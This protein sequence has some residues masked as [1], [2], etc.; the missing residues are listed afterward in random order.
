VKRFAPFG[1]ITSAIAILG[2]ALLARIFREPG[3]SKAVWT[4]AAAAIAVQLATFAVARRYANSGK[5]MI[6]WGIGAI[7]RVAALAAYGFAATG[8]LGLPLAPA[9]LSFALFVFVSTVIEPL[10]LSA[11]A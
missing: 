1:L 3:A 5:V 10:F 6:G 8:S 9:L 2:A 4:S 7:I 11:P